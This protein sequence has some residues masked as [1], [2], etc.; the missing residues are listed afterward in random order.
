MEIS[1]SERYDKDAPDALFLCAFG[2]LAK[3]KA[4]AAPNKVLTAI[5][6]LGSGMIRAMRQLPPPRGMNF[7]GARATGNR[8]CKT[9]AGLLSVVRLSVIQ[10]R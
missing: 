9:G 4:S 7:R 10:R 3:D 6:I 1:C 2:G 8:N 5:Q